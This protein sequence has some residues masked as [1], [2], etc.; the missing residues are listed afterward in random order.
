MLPGGSSVADVEGAEPSHSGV[1]P[2]T[3]GHHEDPPIPSGH[4]L[5]PRTECPEW[6]GPDSQEDLACLDHVLLRFSPLMLC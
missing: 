4:L 2:E 5:K 6:L 3:G 1:T